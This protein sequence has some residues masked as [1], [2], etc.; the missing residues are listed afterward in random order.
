MLT[1]RTFD[2]RGGTLSLKTTTTEVKNTYIVY[3][4]VISL[5]SRDMP[6]RSDMPEWKICVFSGSLR[7][8]GGG[9]FAYW[10]A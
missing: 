9:V 10:A 8:T 1:L 4:Q 6:K 5:V 3:Q 2:K 7:T